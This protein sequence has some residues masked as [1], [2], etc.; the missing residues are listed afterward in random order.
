MRKKA[1]KTCL[2]MILASVLLSFFLLQT[3]LA[4]GL[5]YSKKQPALNI[6]AEYEELQ[7]ALTQQGISPRSSMRILM[8]T[9]VDGQEE[10][11]GCE[12]I[13][14]KITWLESMAIKEPVTITATNDARILVEHISDI[15][16]ET[17]GI[18]KEISALV[19]E[20]DNVKFMTGMAAGRSICTLT[21][22]IQAPVA[23]G[24]FMVSA[25]VAAQTATNT[26]SNYIERAFQVT[27]G[28]TVETTAETIYGNFPFDVFGEV[29]YKKQEQNPDLIISLDIYHE[30]TGEIVYELTGADY[31]KDNTYNIGPMVFPDSCED[32]TYIVY[33]TLADGWDIIGS[34]SKKITYIKSPLTVE[35]SLETIH[36]TEAFDVFGLVKYK[37]ANPNP[38]FVISLDVYNKETGEIV[39]E[40]TGTDYPSDHAYQIKSLVFPDYCTDGVYVVYLTLADGMDIIGSA[41]K[42]VTYIK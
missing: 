14:V 29:N 37:S 31:P 15:V 40:M 22:K 24:E 30:E 8:Q 1:L 41:S 32:G 4:Q 6:P 42:E 39:Y 19:L 36:G 18:Q 27:S 20:K 23:A 28:L 10:I 16:F 3:A 7:P 11:S 13:E 34:A 21:F 33:V 25:K 5:D 38:D 35:T 2:S 26:M 17:D 12:E 9:S